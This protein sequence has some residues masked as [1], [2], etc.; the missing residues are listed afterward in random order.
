MSQKLPLL[1]F[2][3]SK[4]SGKEF[5]IVVSF[6]AMSQKLTLVRAVNKVDLVRICIDASSE[7]CLLANSKDICEFSGKKYIVL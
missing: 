6:L 7:F 2:A 4:F 5:V 3:V 1:E